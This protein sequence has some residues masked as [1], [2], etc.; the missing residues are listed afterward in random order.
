MFATTVCQSRHSAFTIA[1]HSCRAGDYHRTT[2]NTSTIFHSHMIWNN[3]KNECLDV[4]HHPKNPQFVCS[5]ICWVSPWVMVAAGLPLVRRCCIQG[6]RWHIVNP[7]EILGSHSQLGDVHRVPRYH[8]GGPDASR[9][10]V[11][12]KMTTVG[13]WWWNIQRVKFSWAFW[14]LQ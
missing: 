4:S 2:K 11:E 6:S 8:V 10:R 7:R 9:Q 13:N 12:R 5:N 3:Y 1:I 14:E